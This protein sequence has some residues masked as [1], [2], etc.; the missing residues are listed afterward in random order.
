[1]NHKEQNN[2]CK[3][4]HPL[5]TSN[6]PPPPEVIKGEEEY[7]VEEILDSKM[8]RGKL[9]FKI[10]WEG[11]GLEH[12]G[13]EYAAEVHAPKWVADFYWKNTATPRQIRA[14]VRGTPCTI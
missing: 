6:I 8:F 13:W 12:D 14:P 9:K 11:Y 10:K 3:C 5:Q 7:L 4:P 2:R 1:M